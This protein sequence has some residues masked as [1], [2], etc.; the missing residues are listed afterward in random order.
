MKIVGQKPDV[1]FFTVAP[2]VEVTSRMGFL[3]MP[4]GGASGVPRKIK[5]LSISAE[6]YLDGKKGFEL[7]RAEI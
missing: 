6:Q 2:Y 7:T 5:S 4:N 3:K 1:R